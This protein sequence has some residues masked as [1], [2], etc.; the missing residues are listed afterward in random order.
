M[1][2]NVAI[3]LMVLLLTSCFGRRA[4][5]HPEEY[6][7]TEAFPSDIKKEG[8]VLLVKELEVGKLTSNVQNNRVEKLMQKY[9]DKPYVMVSSADLTSNSKF[10]DKNIY[11]YLLTTDVKGTQSIDN[12]PGMAGTHFTYRE[13]YF[14][15]RLLNKTYPGTGQS[16]DSYEADM[17]IV[18]PYLSKMK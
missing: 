6:L 14:V 4:M 9:Y 3:A 1:K 17:K 13:V 10:S 8:Y 16:L 12:G 5:E 18:A 7:N 15:D 11:R 2:T